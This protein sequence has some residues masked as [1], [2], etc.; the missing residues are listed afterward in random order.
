MF[1]VRIRTGGREYLGV[2]DTGATISIVAKKNLPCWSLK[3]TVTTAAIRMGDGHVVHSCGDCEVEVPMG[4]GTIA[5]RFYL[6]DTEAL[7]VYWGLTSSCST[8][9]YN[10]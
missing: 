8:P 7:V 6:M 10:P 5:H 1:W 3:N 9:R 4:C 2:L